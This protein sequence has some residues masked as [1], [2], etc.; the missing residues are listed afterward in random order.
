MADSNP[1]KKRSIHHKYRVSFI[2]ED[3]FDEVRR[4]RLSVFNIIFFI[5]VSLIVASAIV[6]SV[7]FY[8]PIREY[9]P[10]YPD[11]ETQ[12]MMVQ[13]AERLDSLMV[14]IE[15]EKL[16]WDGVRRI[17]QGEVSNEVLEDTSAAHKKEMIIEQELLR[18][19]QEEIEFRTQVEQDEQYNLS[20]LDK[21]NEER[22]EKTVFFSPVKGMITSRFNAEIGHFGVD[23]AT[24]PNAHILAVAS[25]T[26]I[27]VDQSITTG[28]IISI[29]HSNNVITTYRHASKILKKV[30]E[31]V[32]TGEVIGYV[33]N[34][35]TISTGDHLHFELWKDGEAVDPETFIVF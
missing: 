8:T 23:I 16:Y 30:G 21:A 22:T 12:M 25:G 5:I 15:Q 17:L 6:V 19:S 2:N 27:L 24:A 32:K 13:N 14:Q 20:L 1:K 7:I 18:A 9:V 29:Q 10:G 11:S 33:G 4:V 34:T 28:N 35:G 31:K 3:T 26:V